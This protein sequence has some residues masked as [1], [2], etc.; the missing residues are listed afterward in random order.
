MHA[1]SCKG[2][3]NK[4][5]LKH[6]I[7]SISLVFQHDVIYDGNEEV[8]TE[9]HDRINPDQLV[10]AAFP[11]KTPTS[12]CLSLQLS[13]EKCFSYDTWFCLLK[14]NWSSDR[15]KADRFGLGITTVSKHSVQNRYI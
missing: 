10:D 7:P 6:L 15:W 11:S 5:T 4:S 13:H 2:V 3:E 8:Q 1:L 9:I 14:R 12:S